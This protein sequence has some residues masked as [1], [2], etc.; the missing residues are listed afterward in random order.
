MPEVQFLAIPLPRAPCPQ[1]SV[2]YARAGRS[3]LPSY[4]SEHGARAASE[5]RLS[6]FGVH[7]QG[8]A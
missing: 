2:W 6:F 8:L 1:V 4:I 7:M 3:R 5:C